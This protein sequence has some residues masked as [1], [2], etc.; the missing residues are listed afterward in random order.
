MIRIQTSGHAQILNKWAQDYGYEIRTIQS[1]RGYIY[2]R[3]G[4]LLAGNKEVYEVGVELQYVRNPTAI[5]TAVATVTGAD[6]NQV[7]AAATRP[8]K[9]GESV[10][11][12]LADFVD[13]AKV[14]QLSKLKQEYERATGL[15]KIPTFPPCG[16]WSGRL[17]CSAFILKTAWQ[18]T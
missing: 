14:D 9:E 5:A 17:I 11:A 7:L 10:Y 8:Y 15:E 12:P 6:F 18:P 2:D 4:H 3:W 1:E 13:A 16:D